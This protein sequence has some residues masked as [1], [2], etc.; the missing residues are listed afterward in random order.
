MSRRSLLT[1]VAV[2]LVVLR[3]AFGWW[4]TGHRV[5][6]RIAALHLTVQARARVA[7]ILGV[8]DSV[9]S[10]AD[11]LAKVST[12]A[13]E[14]RNSTKTG[15]WHYIDLTLQDQ[16]SDFSKRCE[17][18]NCAPARIRLFALQLAGGAKDPK[19]SD[20]DA[21]RFVVHFVGDIHQPLHTIADADLGG[22]CELLNPPVDTARNLHALWDGGILKEISDDDRKLASDLESAIVANHRAARWSK[23]GVDEWTWESHRLA[24]RLVYKRLHVPV[25][26]ALFPQGCQNAPEA[27]RD[28]KPAVDE[29]YVAAMKPVVMERLSKGGLRLAALLNH[30]FAQQSQ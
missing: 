6:A 20:L 18:D 9:D 23:G 1:A 2:L 24:M 3:P 28:F 14:V 25:E 19:W 30:T 26:P 21:L 27:I 22:N 16:K 5:V 7:A 11:A 17:N 29:S 13:D 4:E 10:V 12:W 15:E 8:S